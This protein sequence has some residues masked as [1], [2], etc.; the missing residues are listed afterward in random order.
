M[1]AV[2]QLG[3]AFGAWASQ[4]FMPNIDS[5]CDIL[6]N[7]L[8][9]IFIDVEGEQ[10]RTYDDFLS[11]ASSYY[12]SDDGYEAYEAA[13]EH[14]RDHALQFMGMRSVFLATGVSG[15]F[16]LFEKQL[17]RHINKELE[18]WL[19]AS[20]SNWRDLEEL[21]PKFDGRWRQDEPCLDLVDAFRDADLKELRLVANAVKHGTDG[22]SYK[23]LQRSG[24]VVVKEKRVADDWTVGPHSVFG[25]S[26]SIQPDDVRRYQ[27]SIKRF[28]DLD[29]TF[30]APR[31]AFK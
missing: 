12:G 26:L 19:T 4:Y 28:W 20:L 29:G 2:D 23:E 6:L 22:Q 16:H 8:D 25:M 13:E 14:A 27:A 31:S 11:A 17:Y 9:A 5:Y 7:R 3:I 18:E 1:S 10:Q 15:L 30:F 21:V 24:A